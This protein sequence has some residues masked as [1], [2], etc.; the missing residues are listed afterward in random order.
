MTGRCRILEAS[1]AAGGADAELA[2]RPAARRVSNFEPKWDG[3]RTIVFR[4]GNQLD[5]DSR[6]ER[7]LTRYFPYVVE[8][9][10]THLPS[11]RRDERRGW[12]RSGSSC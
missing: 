9:V 5:L 11:R 7:P 3:F 1:H 4:D 8:A 12:R 2:G 6:N 10:R